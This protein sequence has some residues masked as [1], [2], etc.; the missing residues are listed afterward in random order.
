MKNFIILLSCLLL[1]AACSQKNNEEKYTMHGTSMEPNIYDGDALSVEFA[2]GLNR[3]DI[4]IFENP[5]FAGEKLVKRVIALPEETVEFSKEAIII[6][7]EDN[8]YG[9]ILEEAYLNGGTQKKTKFLAD[10]SVFDLP[11]DGYFVMGDNR[12]LSSDSR[13]Y[14]S[15]NLNEINP[16]KYR[17]Y[18]TLDDI[19]GVVGKIE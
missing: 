11:S 4:V 18:I 2:T 5:N 8:P 17:F 9:F 1:L 19:I 13:F 12:E 10:Y 3:G 7:S 6:K 14:F 15:H 16:E